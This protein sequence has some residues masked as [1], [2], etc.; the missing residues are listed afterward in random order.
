ME[1]LLL[2]KVFTYPTVISLSFNK[3]EIALQKTYKIEKLTN[4]NATVCA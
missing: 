3:R 1:Y 2:T 4:K